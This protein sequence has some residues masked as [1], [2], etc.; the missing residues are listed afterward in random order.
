MKFS[1][2]LSSLGLALSVSVQAGPTPPELKIPPAQPPAVW[3]SGRWNLLPEIEAAIVAPT[4]PDRDF[5]V[6]DYGASGNGTDDNYQAFKDAIEACSAAEGGRVV[7]PEGVYRIEGPIHLKSDIN[8]HLQEGSY[9]DF[10]YTPEKYLVGEARHDGCVLVRWEGT[11][12]YNYSPLIYAINATNVALTGS[13]TVDGNVD[14]GWIDWRGPDALDRPVKNRM[15]HEGVPIE[16]RIFGRKHK[17]QPGTIEFYFCRNVL[18]EG[19]TAKKP[20]ERNIHPVWCDNVTIRNVDVQ[21]GMPG[22]REDDGIDP[23]SCWNVLIEGC[24]IHC[25]DDGIGIKSGRDNDGWIKDLNDPDLKGRSWPQVMPGRPSRNIIIRNCTFY[26]AHNMVAIGSDLSGGCENVFVYDCVGGARESQQSVFE[27]KSKFN[28]GGEIRNIHFRNCR[29]Y[30]CRSLLEV[31]LHYPYGGK[32][33]EDGPFRITKVRDIYMENIEV[34]QAEGVALDFNGRGEEWMHDIW[35]KDIVVHEAEGEIREEFVKDLHLHN[36]WINGKRQP[37]RLPPAP[38]RIPFQII[39]LKD[40]PLGNFGAPGLNHL[41]DG[42]VSDPLSGSHGRPHV[43]QKSKS[44]FAVD[45]NVAYPGAPEYGSP[46]PARVA[47]HIYSSLSLDPG[48]RVLFYHN[49]E[50]AIDAWKDINRPVTVEA[51]MPT[52]IAWVDAIKAALPDSMVTWYSKPSSVRR[53]RSLSELTDILG[54]MQDELIKR[55]DF[56]SPEVYFWEKDMPQSQFDATLETF[57]K[58]LLWVRKRYPNKLL[59]P[60]VWEEYLV[61]SKI[62]HPRDECDTCPADT[63]GNHRYATEETYNNDGAAYCGGV[64]MPES[65]FRAVLQMCHDMGCDGVFYWANTSSWGAYWTDTNR[66]GIRTF[67]NFANDLGGALPVGEHS[68]TF[69]PYYRLSR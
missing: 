40:F 55:L 26:G 37:D 50:S 67:L 24:T 49:G 14:E 17:L 5:N 11:W 61:A 3:D 52:C 36:V 29:V 57:R 53:G 58:K 8:L 32:N 20:L 62:W 48:G 41:V 28:R 13:G 60:V 18:I 16:E 31:D 30:R 54:P 39:S 51:A 64:A 47:A 69:P 35:L 44:R 7:V 25:R 56:I 38:G 59:L 15:A 22:R 1:P 45:L 46:D 4:F 65:R 2:L 42:V 19:I 68:A 34:D 66:S 27:I 63:T 23:D 12:I 21:Q 43:M 6:I 9:L 33:S 10:A